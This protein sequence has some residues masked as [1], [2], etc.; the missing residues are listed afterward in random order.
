MHNTE[1]LKQIKHVSESYFDYMSSHYPVMCSSDEFYFFPR[2]N[3]SIDFLNILDNLDKQKIN[4]DTDY[5]KKLA[6]RLEKLKTDNLDF[7]KDLPNIPSI[8]EHASNI[9]GHTI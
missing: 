7:D 2:A 1:A 6:S 9:F 5:I 4:Q 3:K 8:P